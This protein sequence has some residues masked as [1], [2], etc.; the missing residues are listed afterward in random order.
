MTN[1]IPGRGPLLGALIPVKEGTT[2]M[3]EGAIDPEG[4]GGIHHQAIGPFRLLDGLTTRR[5]PRWQGIQGNDVD[6]VVLQ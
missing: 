3:T 6:I 1:R 5:L 4:I 2:V